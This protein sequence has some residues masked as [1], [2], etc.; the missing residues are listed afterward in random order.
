MTSVLQF[1][2]PQVPFGWAESRETH[3]AVAMAIHAVAG[4]GRA[5]EAIWDM[6][7]YTEWDCVTSA[8]ENY[9]AC[10]LFPAEAGGRYPWGGETIVI[11]DAGR[12]RRYEVSANGTAL[13][14]YVGDDEQ[15]ARDA[16][17]RDAGYK[18]EADMVERLEQQSAL[19]A[20]P[21]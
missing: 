4:P 19:I 18:S 13:G 2:T 6:P 21:L 3:P 15:E 7:T 8:V 1:L 14:I 12:K 5:P 17:A 11:P 20:K 16:C 10:G 9:V